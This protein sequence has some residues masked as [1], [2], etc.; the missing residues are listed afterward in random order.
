VASSLRTLPSDQLLARLHAL[1]RRGSAVEVELLAHL[2]EVDARRLYLREACSSMFS[3]CV[4][5]L[6][7]AEPVAYKRIAAARVARRHPEVLDAVRQ[8]DLHV[9]GAS[10]LAPQ[11][12][13]E[14]SAE[15]IQAVRHRTADEI[16]RLLVDRKP[17]PDVPPSVRRAPA[18]TPTPAASPATKTPG[19]AAESAAP[20][21]EPEPAAHTALAG[22]ALSPPAPLA[23]KPG[24]RADTQ[25]L[26]GERYFVRFTADGELHGQLQELRALMRHQIPDGDLGKIMARAVAVLL[27]QVRRRKFAE[28]SAPRP[29]KPPSECPSRQIPAS[30]RRAVAERDGGR[31]TFVS[32]S[33]RRCG[34]REFLEFH[35]RQPWARAPVHAIED[36]ALRCRAHNQYE[37]CRDFGERHMAQ[38]RKRKAAAPNAEPGGSA[39]LERERSA[40]LDSDPVRP[41]TPG[42]EGSGKQALIA[43]VIRPAFDGAGHRRY[44]DRY[45]SVWRRSPI[46]NATL[47]NLA[48]RRTGIYRLWKRLPKKLKQRLAIFWYD[49]LSRFNTSDDMVFL[50]HGYAST[51]GDP[52]FLD[53]NEHERKHQYP[54]Q[55]YHHV[56][57]AADWPGKDAVE[58]SCGR[59][60]GAAYIVRTFSPRSYIGIDLSRASIDFCRKHFDIPGLSFQL[61]DA[62][63]LPLPDQSCD[64]V[65]NVESSLSYPD[66][67]AFFSE[68]KRVL[69]PGGRFLYCD[70]RAARRVGRMWKLLKR[71]GLELIRK[72]QASANI[73]RALEFDNDRKHALLAKHVPR[74]LRRLA[75]NLT[76]TDG[77]Q[78]SESRCF[79]TGNK[80]YWIFALRKPG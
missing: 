42:T 78:K 54:I 34:A 79:E 20:E 26:G 6:H 2:G 77:S 4:R 67:G 43:R 23:E 74:P 37:A 55:L 29:A 65:I 62:L 8:G 3:Y 36:I 70:Y 48:A 72:E 17:K 10:Q 33:G 31:C 69:R 15:L 57:A 53:L 1:I 59:G 64:I 11:L 68:V 21:G 66:L 63:A 39:S 25:P 52:R 28:S 16:R 13:P 32:S 40:Q 49:L 50:N 18:P 35:H 27:E 61:G 75:E 7:F 45:N 41:G 9:T 71:S 46:P 56:A 76:F 12:T 24:R 19:D 22:S 60:G 58:V 14:N 38:F 5:V 44:Q 47:P 30:I 51:E 80:V 73:I